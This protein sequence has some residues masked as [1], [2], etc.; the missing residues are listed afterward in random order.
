MQN[1]ILEAMAA[2]I[3]VVATPEAAK[4]IAATNGQEILIDGEP[5]AFAN[6]VVEL[7]ANHEMKKRISSLAREFVEKEY[8]WS[9]TLESLDD[10][11]GQLG[12]S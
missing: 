3:P 2:G 5:V 9:G 8:S 6:R 10:I 7:L 4:G 1:K 11:L 12:I